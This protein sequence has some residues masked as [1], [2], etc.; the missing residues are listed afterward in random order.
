MN[1]NKLNLYRETAIEVLKGLSDQILTKKE[2]GFRVIR[3]EERE[4]VTELDVFVQEHI[5]KSF[6]EALGECEILSEEMIVPTSGLN[7]FWS[8]DPID[9]THNFIAGLPGYG[10]SAAYIEDNEVLLGV[11]CL[12][13]SGHLYHA[14]KDEGAYKD[15][16]RISSSDVSD[17]SKSIISYDNQFHLSDKSRM[18]YDSLINEAFTTRISGSSVVDSC[19][20]SEGSLSA[21]VYNSTKL[22]DIAAGIILVK[23]AGG[24]VS[25][26][27]GND[28]DLENISDVIFSAKGIH[29]KLVS[30]MK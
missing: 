17:L 8:V 4:L 25:D 30:L 26:F 22:C 28:L 11:I 21:R 6:K 7:S 14:T 16:K 3:K 9:G 18:N 10:I 1:S 23:E 2:Q 5:K 20:I 29:T 27:R 19:F 13:E 15:T 12:P 24:I